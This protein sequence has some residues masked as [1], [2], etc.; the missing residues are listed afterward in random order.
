MAGYL[1]I[2]RTGEYTFYLTSDDGSWL[3]IDG[4]KVIDNGGL[5]APVTK[6]AKITL[7]KGYH[8]IKVRM[9]EHYGGAYA[10]LEW[11]GPS[12]GRELVM[13]VFKTKPENGESSNINYYEKTWDGR[14][15]VTL[16]YDTP[17]NSVKLISIDLLTTGGWCGRY[18]GTWFYG[19][20]ISADWGKLII[21]AGGESVTL[22]RGHH[23]IILSAKDGV[24]DVYVDGKRIARVSAGDNITLST[25]HPGCNHYGWRSRWDGRQTLKIVEASLDALYAGGIFITNSESD[26]KALNEFSS[27]ISLQDISTT[28]PLSMSREYSGHGWYY[29]LSGLK[30]TVASPKPFESVSF[31]VSPNIKAHIS[32]P[33]GSFDYTPETYTTVFVNDKEVLRIKGGGEI[34]VRNF[35]SFGTVLVNGQVKTITGSIN[36]LK[37]GVWGQFYR[38]NYARGKVTGG[39]GTITITNIRKI[40]PLISR[41]DIITAEKEIFVS[42]KVFIR[43]LGPGELKVLSGDK[44]EI[45]DVDG[46]KV[47]SSTEG[48]LIIKPTN[49]PAA[50]T[51]LPFDT[52]EDYYTVSVK[53]PGM[54]EIFE[55]RIAPGETKTVSVPNGLLH[56]TDK[57][58]INLKV[59][60]ET[61][62]KEIRIIQGFTILKDVRDY[63]IKARAY[64]G[65]I[66]ADDKVNVTVLP[67]ESLTSSDLPPG[68]TVIEPSRDVYLPGTITLHAKATG[69]VTLTKLVI[70]VN[71]G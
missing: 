12:F 32:T 65:D 10:K 24:S 48:K 58:I 31:H 43:N 68:I 23:E 70:R 56:L 37:V 62:N 13:D 16:Y 38:S 45:L 18:W 49:L 51:Y 9:H 33:W 59:M 20:Y 3:W 35:G 44:E 39:D 50:I 5:H 8:E 57:G 19:Y 27:E 4:R 22:E 26:A 2:P 47:F 71:G 40:T 25:K 14:P 67:L 34:E 69:D 1:H 41:H 30:T 54:K 28:A 53:V 15:P 61:L 60:P 11:S 7:G 29:Y 42:N 55:Y 36:D 64:I 17:S 46:E 6:S 21:K 52:V 66:S 63:E